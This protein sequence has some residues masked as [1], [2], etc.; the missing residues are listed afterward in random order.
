MHP[1]IAINYGLIVVLVRIQGKWPD[2]ALKMIAKI[3]ENLRRI[4]GQQPLQECKVWRLLSSKIQQSILEI[5]AKH[6]QIDTVVPI[7]VNVV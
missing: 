4:L 5:A 6:N 7:K 1:D 2:M 3:G